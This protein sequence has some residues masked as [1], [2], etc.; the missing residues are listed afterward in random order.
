M[1]ATT[2]RKLENIISY[3]ASQGLDKAYIYPRCHCTTEFCYE[4]ATIWQGCTCA[5]WSEDLLHARA[6][7]AAIREADNPDL[8]V[9]EAAFRNLVEQIREAGAPCD[10]ADLRRA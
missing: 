4:C 3:P 8:A 2:S 9:A 6:A 10:H 7:R 1:V 5:L